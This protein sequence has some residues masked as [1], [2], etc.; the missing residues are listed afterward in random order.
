MFIG[1]TT[2]QYPSDFLKQIS[3]YPVREIYAK[4]IAL[5]W[6]EYPITEITGNIVTGSISVDG[7]S[8]TRRTCSLTVIADNTNAEINKLKWEL[9]TKFAIL[10]G[11]KNFVNDKYPEII[12]IQQ[13]IFILTSF[14]Q[15]VN[16]SGNTISIQGKDKMCLLD[17]SIGGALNATHKFSPVAVLGPDGY[18]NE[19]EVLIKDIIQTAVHDY[20]QEPY[21][22][23]IINDLEDCSV[24]LLQYRVSNKRLFIYDI[25]VSSDFNFYTSQLG[26]EGIGIFTRPQANTN[27]TD[28]TE[29]NEG[30]AFQIGNLWY[31][32]V[33][34][35]DFGDTAGYR[36]TDLTYVSDLTLNVG[37]S[38][39]AMLDKI[40]NQ[41]GEFE[42]YYDTFGTFIFQRKKIYH[43][44][45]WNGATM[46]DRNDTFYDYIN[47]TKTVF[48]FDNAFLI[49]SLNNKPNY[50]N[51]RNDFTIWGVNGAKSPIHLRY[52]IDD[53]PRYYF[54]NTYHKLYYSVDLSNNELINILLELSVLATAP[55]TT[56]QQ[57][58]I[59]GNYTLKV[60]WREIIYQMSYDRRRGERCVQLFTLALKQNFYHYDTSK[61]VAT[62]EVNQTDR[63]LYSECFYYN[64]ETKSFTH[65]KNSDEYDSLL[66]KDTLFFGSFAL[67]SVQQDL[68]TEINLWESCWN[69]GYDAYYADLIDFWHLLYDTRSIDEIK[70]ATDITDDAIKDR[71]DRY[72]EWIA[73]GH[74]NPDL[75]TCRN[76]PSNVSNISFK[77]PE[78]LLF[79]IDFIGQ[80]SELKKYSVATIGRRP[81]AINDDKVSA[82]FFRE[83][84]NVLFIDPTL[85]A[86]EDSSLNYV[87]LN[88]GGGLINYFVL[89]SQGKSAKE[90]LDS[91]VYDYTYFQEN[92]NL[93]CL[94]LYY[95]E[96][97]TLIN[98]IN[99]ETGING[100]FIIQSFNIPLNGDGMMS[101]TATRLAERIL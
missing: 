32:I 1:A 64:N 80:N 2:H 46:N 40:I 51:I 11:L 74:W 81:K 10:I 93:S 56:A 16:A 30:V 7:K 35:I 17:G 85:Q 87:K 66:A 8:S 68:L 27:R 89:S 45:V 28:Y 9:N 37:E 83:I 3:T 60:D 21:E 76:Y 99:T 15:V 55:S 43:N 94:P 88:L 23:I 26:F 98:I 12:W 78:S 92:I 57:Q 79:W 58:N 95:L 67:C 31:R 77:N 100:E 82:I 22:N 24:E 36:E 42:Y 101:I 34:K 33:K 71:V 70:K 6:D 86:P 50:L 19:E 90:V 41:L 97:N 38:I 52:A 69:T 96:P 62:K 54:S 14:S 39:T 91:M 72:N 5:S 44:V 84:P 75:F 47:S 61:K 73:N 20:A 18:E 13:G 4:L 65:P 59:I 53:M 25:S 63:Y 29:V 48:E 49:E